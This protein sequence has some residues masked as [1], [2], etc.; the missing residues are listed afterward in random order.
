MNSLYALFLVVTMA[1][2]THQDSV[3]GVYTSKDV[4]EAKSLELTSRTYCKP[5]NT[6]TVASASSDPDFA[7]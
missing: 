6:T 2:G 3:M 7:G 1:N 5:L 4:C